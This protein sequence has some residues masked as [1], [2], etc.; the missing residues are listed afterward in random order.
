FCWL[1]QTHERVPQVRYVRIRQKDDRRYLG[2]RRVVRHSEQLC[3]RN[4][5]FSYGRQNL[6]PSSSSRNR[7]HVLSTSHAS[8]LRI[9]V[10]RTSVR[11]K[12]RPMCRYVKRV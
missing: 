11:R 5:R 3:A 1:R 6:L 8:I 2:N 9:T 10:P 7:Q 4:L 12:S